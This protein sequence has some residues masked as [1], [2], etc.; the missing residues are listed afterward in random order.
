[1]VHN[2]FEKYAFQKSFDLSTDKSWDNIFNDILKVTDVESKNIKFLDY[3]CG[4]GKYF[5]KLISLG[6]L[7]KNI[8]GVEISKNRLKRCHAINFKNAILVDLSPKLPYKDNEFDV[9]N[10]M[11]VIEHIPKAKIDLILKEIK[12][13]LKQN[14]CLI[15]STPNYPIKRF[16]DFYNALIYFKYKRIF[17][18]PT[19]ISPYSFKE[20]K[21]KLKIYFSF[22]QTK[23]FKDGFLYKYIKNPLFKNKIMYICRI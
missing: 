23:N 21:N 12:R 14:G 19:H 6:L 20:L 13:V 10:F 11:E 7:N 5:K 22:I 1:M 2:D 18:D 3:G 17:D 16:Y 8:H 15:I 4:D 9:I